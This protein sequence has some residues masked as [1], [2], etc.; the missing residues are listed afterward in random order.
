MS[1]AIRDLVDTAAAGRPGV[2]QLRAGAV[3]RAAARRTSFVLTRRPWTASTRTVRP[4]PSGCR[5]S[6]RWRTT[7]EPWS[8]STC[9]RASTTSSRP[10]AAAASRSARTATTAKGRRSPRRSS[11]AFGIDGDPA[12]AAGLRPCGQR[13]GAHG[14]GDLGPRHAIARPVPG[15]RPRAGRPRLAGADCHRRASRGCATLATSGMDGTAD[16]RHGHRWHGHQALPRRGRAGRALPG[17]RLVPGRLHRRSTRS[18]TRSCCSS[19]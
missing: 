6:P 18:S 19:A 4:S 3:R 7:S 16:L 9:W 17:V 5:R 11:A 12:A 13:L 8:P 14:R 15:P 2:H 1:Q 10:S